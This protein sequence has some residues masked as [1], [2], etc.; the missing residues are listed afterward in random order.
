M[1]QA[2]GL[3]TSLRRRIFGRVI[4]HGGLLISMHTLPCMVL[5]TLPT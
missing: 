1:R 5:T 4:L 3:E 2:L